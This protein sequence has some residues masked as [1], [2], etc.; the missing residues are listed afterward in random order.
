MNNDDLNNPVSPEQNVTENRPQQ[1]I[2]KDV[3]TSAP[4]APQSQLNDSDSSVRTIFRRSEPVSSKSVLPNRQYSRFV[5]TMKLL[6]PGL[7]I[8]VFLSVIIVT[9]MQNDDETFSVSIPTESI[10]SEEEEMAKPEMTGFDEKG[11]PYN[12]TA[13]T[14]VKDNTNQ[15]IIHMEQVSGWMLM[16]AETVQTNNDEAADLFNTNSLLEAAD[17]ENQ[18]KISSNAGTLNSESELM[19]LSGNVVMT[20]GTQYQIVTEAASINM[21]NRQAR[22][23]KETA[24]TLDWGTVDA[25]SFEADSDTKTVVFI[26]NVRTKIESNL[27]TDDQ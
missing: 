2:A 10:V 19:D 21:K 4:S 22:S 11:R 27:K 5:S 25:D 1:R 23:Q 12:V 3:E 9:S 24:V 6:L 8:I 16:E 15:N 7:A 17:P 14:A 13:A 18:L 20:I 26:G